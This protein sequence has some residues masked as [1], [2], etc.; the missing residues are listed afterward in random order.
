MF[1]DK[2]QIALLIRNPTFKD[3]LKFSLFEEGILDKFKGVRLRNICD[4]IHQDG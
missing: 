1:F 3:E 4:G 2:K